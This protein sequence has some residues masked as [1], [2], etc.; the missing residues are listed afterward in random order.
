M[1]VFSDD[2]LL[3]HVPKCAGQFAKR[4]LKRHVPGMNG[5][6]D[7]DFPFPIGHIPLRDIEA[8]TGRPLDSW[9]KVVAI[10]RNPYEQQ[11]S[12]YLFWLSRYEKGGR[13][14]HDVYTHRVTQRA[15]K[16]GVPPLEE[17][18][19][20]PGCDFHVWYQEAIGS[21][22]KST[23]KQAGYLDFGSYYRF[24]V[25]VDGEIPPNVEL[26]RYERLN[27][28]FPRAV[29]EFAGGVHDPGEPTNVGPAREPTRSYYS[30]PAMELVERKFTYA[31]ERYYEKWSR[32]V[33]T[34]TA[35]AV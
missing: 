27:E 32:P 7:L 22:V 9:A 20:H 1:A 35:G 26:V 2:L 8:F 24:W 4:Y 33:W 25:E 19:S 5:P 15:L 13:H 23:A 30:L 6:E 17:W 16:R 29:A 12:Q 34:V 31:F 3:I 11:L 28:D 18:L 14:E 10:V 21:K